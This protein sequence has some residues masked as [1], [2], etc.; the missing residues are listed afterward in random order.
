MVGELRAAGME[1]G[2]HTLT[3]PI[4]LRVSDAEV[5][6]EIAAGLERPCAAQ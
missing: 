3:H 1:I 6:A 2:G 4:L 5:R